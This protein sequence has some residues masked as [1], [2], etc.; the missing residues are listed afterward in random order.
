MSVRVMGRCAPKN[1]RLLARGLMLLAA[2]SFG[3]VAWSKPDGAAQSSAGLSSASPLWP[4]YLQDAWVAVHR[5]PFNSDSTPHP[6]AE[7]YV[8]DG[9]W[10]ARSTSTAHEY[11]GLSQVAI[12]TGVIRSERFNAA[13]VTNGKRSAP[14]L[15]AF[16]LSGK[17]LW[18]SHDWRND[19][20]NWVDTNRLDQFSVME[21]K[22]LDY[23]AVTSS[24]ILDTHGNGYIADCK[25]LWKFHRNGHL[26]WKWSLPP[27][28]DYA[29]EGASS[30]LITAFFAD[31]A[32]VGG[33]TASGRVLIFDRDPA[34]RDPVATFT[35]P[36]WYRTQPY[37]DD[38]ISSVETIMN[39]CVWYPG[40]VDGVPATPRN[41]PEAWMMDPDL[42][43]PIAAGFVG[44]G[45]PNANTPAVYR[46]D[47]RTTGIFFAVQI[48]PSGEEG[49]L[50]DTRLVRIDFDPVDQTLS[51]A[52]DIEQSPTAGLMPQGNGSATSPTLSTLG[53]RVYVGD[54]ERTLWVFRAS[55]GAEM[56]H[57]EVGPMA[58]SITA[59][60]Y[61]GTVW[62]GA[63]PDLVRLDPITAERLETVNLS[64]ENGDPVNIDTIY[65]AY[66]ELPTY[67]GKPPTAKIAGLVVATPDHLIFPVNLG[68]EL[69]QE[70]PPEAQG[71]SFQGMDFLFWPIHTT[72]V[73]LERAPIED[74]DPETK[75][76]ISHVFDVED[77]SEVGLMPDSQG[78]VLSAMFSTTT[79]FFRCLWD[80]PLVG[81]PVLASLGAMELRHNGIVP[82]APRGGVTG[83]VPAQSP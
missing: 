68:F 59:D 73:A 78:R 57:H 10:Q 25:F 82:V 55:D 35:D 23:C 37:D 27:E 3:L 21:M 54:S 8:I 53:D 63:G 49:S 69:Q 47:D 46:Y 22:T 6:L 74:D 83:Y 31:P 60:W 19:A 14:H 39:A 61:R 13:Y 33:V 77:S 64:Y 4:P 56:G 24:V 18:D 50:P 58:G 45:L 71:S 34:G 26:L 44:G 79:S 20:M 52:W 9:G 29:I 70:T 41:N 51:L 7:R 75:A 40:Y 2:L 17:F 15:M 42:V 11:G 1:M 76:V 48:E 72:A 38:S 66:G 28:I 32:H 65:E 5:D 62:V 12:G 43:T 36:S 67:K 80:R 30:P 16:D 81:N